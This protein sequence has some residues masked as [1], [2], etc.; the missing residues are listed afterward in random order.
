MEVEQDEESDLNQDEDN[1]ENLIAC[2]FLSNEG[3]VSIRVMIFKIPTPGS[4]SLTECRLR[5][6]RHLKAPLTTRIFASI[7][8]AADRLV[9][10][11]NDTPVAPGDTIEVMRLLVSVLKGA[12]PVIQSYTWYPVPVQ[13]KQP[14]YKKAEVA[15]YDE[16]CAEFPKFDTIQAVEDGGMVKDLMVKNVEMSREE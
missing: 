3:G 7:P 15:V 9:S 4:L 11:S 6:E 13:K 1:E 10:L 14:G 8:Y 2:R 5:S 16:W 12:F